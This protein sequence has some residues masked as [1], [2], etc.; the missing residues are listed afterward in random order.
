[1]SHQENRRKLAEEKKVGGV[2]HERQRGRIVVADKAGAVVEQDHRV[3]RWTALAV[4]GGD[5]RPHLL[6]RRVPA[7]ERGPQVVRRRNAEVER[8]HGRRAE[9]GVRE[10]CRLGVEKRA[11]SALHHDHHVQGRAE[12]DPDRA[13]IAGGERDASVQQLPETAAAQHG[14]QRRHLTASA[15]GAGAAGLGWAAPTDQCRSRSQRRATSSRG[16]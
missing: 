8:R 5:R 11:H 16:G 15:A 1:M 13:V 7:A 6:D 12:L 3:A 14:R 10:E 4:G 9:D 2:L